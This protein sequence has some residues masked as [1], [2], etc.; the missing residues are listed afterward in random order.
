MS[1]NVI[2]IIHPFA[3]TV[4]DADSADNEDHASESVCL[5]L[6]K[7]CLTDMLTPGMVRISQGMQAST[8]KWLA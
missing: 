7:R 6:E 1:T 4:F 5:L 3:E 8:G 2:K